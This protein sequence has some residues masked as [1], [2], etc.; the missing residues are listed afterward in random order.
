[1]TIEAYLFLILALL[2]YFYPGINAYTRKHHNAGAIMLMNLLLG[3]T[4][5][6][7]IA[8]LIWSAT[9]V[10]KSGN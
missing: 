1:M 2:I 8:A 10:K 9:A 3:W 7:W 6:G 5:L 4:L